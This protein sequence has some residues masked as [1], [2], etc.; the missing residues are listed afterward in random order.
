MCAS[1]CVC[2]CVRLCVCVCVCVCAWV[3]MCVCVCARACV[4]V[5]S[6]ASGQLVDVYVYKLTNM[7]ALVVTY[8]ILGFLI[9]II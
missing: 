1:V 9:I 7:G 4:C 3:C 5:W 2:L 8:T 6:H